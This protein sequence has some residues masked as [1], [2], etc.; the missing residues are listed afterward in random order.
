VSFSIRT[1]LAFLYSGLLSLSMILFATSAVW[2]LRQRLTDRVRESLAK[3]IQGVEDF[4]IRETTAKTAAAMIPVEIEEYASTQPEGHLIEVTDAAGSFL[5]RSKPAPTPSVTREDVFV[6][7]GKEYRVRAAASLA[8][9]EASLTELRWLLS[10]LAPLLLLITGGVCYWIGSRALAP[11]DGMTRLARSMG[12]ADLSR[13]L[14]VPSARDELSRLA[15]AWNEMLGRLEKSID[16][17]H[18]FT[19]DAA[20]E[21]RTPLTALRT[22]AELAVRREREANEY[23]ESLEQ[24]VTLSERMSHLLDALLALARGDDAMPVRTV[25]RVELRAL[26]RSVCSEMRPMFASKGVDLA[27]DASEGLP[28][29]RGDAEGLERLLASLVE[30]ALK[31]TAAGG[32]VTIRVEGE[33]SEQVVE[34]SDTGCGIPAE[35]LPHIF[36]RF[37]RVDLSRDRRS[38]GHGL[39]LAIAQQI[40]RF[41]D[42]EIEVRS[43]LGKGSCFRVRLPGT[44]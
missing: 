36:E 40:A 24:V 15:E 27:L 14:P 23:R 26:V 3:R 8:P 20:H 29:V 7:Y 35:S 17:I 38:G 16:R 25:G 37:Y 42:T 39:G 18:R 1:R 12:L 2:L 22:T 11:I 41:H 13:R 19:A 9:V 4:L 44:A 10:V 43:T 32:R 34:V 30:N 6:L 21:L 33:G 5:L 31:Y 28:V